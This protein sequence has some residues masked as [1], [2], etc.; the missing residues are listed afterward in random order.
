MKINNE[1]T[2]YCSKQDDNNDTNIPKDPVMFSGEKNDLFSTTTDGQFFFSCSVV[3]N[4]G[5]HPTC[6][7]AKKV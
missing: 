4:N 7:R 2:T 3:S 6:R 1:K 5:I